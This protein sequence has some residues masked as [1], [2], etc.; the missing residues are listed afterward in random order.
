MLVQ[1]FNKK[2]DKPLGRWSCSAGAQFGVHLVLKLMTNTG[3]ILHV[4]FLNRSSF[5]T[6]NYFS[7]CVPQIE[8]SI[9]QEPKHGGSYLDSKRNR[10][11]ILKLITRR[12]GTLPCAGEDASSFI[13]S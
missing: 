1:G 7:I 13:D 10:K 8:S 3:R 6:E 2:T 5:C 12:L 9:L 11:Y 4:E